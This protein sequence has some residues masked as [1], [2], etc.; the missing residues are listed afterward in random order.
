MK[1]IK[2]F[3]LVI[4]LML[5]SSFVNVKAKTE[6]YT[7]VSGITLNSSVVVRKKA[8][9]KS[10]KIYTFTGGTIIK[11]VGK[12]GNYY[13]VLGTNN[14]TGYV[15]KS[16]VAITFILVDIS[17]QKLY[18]YNNGSKTFTTNVVTGKKG[19]SDT[20]IGHY[21]LNRSNFKKNTYLMNNTHVDYWMPFI[22]SR[23][24]G[25]HDA[26]W[27]SSF[28]GTIYKTNGSHGCVNMPHSAAE[29]LYKYA[30]SKVDVIV[31]P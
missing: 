4:S 25:F 28:G 15:P 6:N 9:N 26:S 8:D 14:Q 13:K 27:R 30:P 22:T 19:V 20:P 31:R 5:V 17:D 23:G 16:A 10:T 21:I 12:S 29:K 7:V 1:K 24:I 3:I 11:L 2:I 18:V